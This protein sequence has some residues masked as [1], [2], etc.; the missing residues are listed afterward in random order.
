MEEYSSLPKEIIEASSSQQDLWVVQKTQC[1]PGFYMEIGSGDGVIMNNTYLLEKCGWM[2]VSV[3]PFPMDWSMRKNPLVRAAIWDKQVQT[4]FVCGAYLG[5]IQDCLGKWKSQLEGVPVVELMTT[6]IQDF[7]Q[8]L[9]I[10]NVIDYLSLD[11]EGSEYDIL[12]AF[13]FDTH[14]VKLITVEHNYEEPK[15]TMIQELL[16]AH[17]YTREK[18]VDVEDFYVK[19]SE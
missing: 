13:P 7:L 15:R 19:T 5:G 14:K 4:N 6:H 16:M 2:G 18:S 17:G 12:A 11:T 10:P 1:V 9:N 3:D 8:M